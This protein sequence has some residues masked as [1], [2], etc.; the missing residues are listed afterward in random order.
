MHEKKYR[1]A[2]EIVI[3]DSRGYGYYP[4]V[5]RKEIGISGTGRAPFFTDANCVLIVRRGATRK[6]V[7]KGIDVLRE[8]LKLR[9][10]EEKQ[11]K[12]DKG[13]EKRG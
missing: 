13:G 9:W 11:P 5:L 1:P 2:G 10:K 7:L 8:D 6:D 12:Q 4:S 3:Y